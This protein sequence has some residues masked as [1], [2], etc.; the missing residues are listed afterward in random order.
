[1]VPY[2]G[3]GP[4]CYA[5][6]TAMLLASIGETIL[7]SRIEVLT[8]VGLS[9]F[10]M[11]GANLIFFSGTAPDVG[12][13]QALQILGFEYTEKASQEGDP[14]PFEELGATLQVSPAV[15]GPLD[16]GYLHYLPFHEDTAGSD[17][18]VLA[19]DMD[20]Q[21]VHLHD[22]EGFP[23]VSLP[24]DQLDLAW[25]AKRIGYRRGSYRHWA[26]PKRVRRP[27]EEEIY[28]GALD[29]FKTCYHNADDLGTQLNWPIGHEAILACAEYVRGGQVSSQETGHM[30]GFAFRLGARRALDFATLFDFRDAA[31]ATMKRTQ[32][33]LFGRCHT[34]AVRKDWASL[35]AALEQLANVE[36]AFRGTLFTC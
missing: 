33:R 18:Y 19:Y 31:L 12:V 30:V 26:S 13:S 3:N 2:S 8:G 20:E 29:F 1:M 27:T 28:D 22:P 10:W 25:K 11:P 7:P 6:A 35:A 5:N 23:H 36:E 15:L 14:P 24:R 9:A 16:M 17:H 32:A 4:Y 21:E 34:L